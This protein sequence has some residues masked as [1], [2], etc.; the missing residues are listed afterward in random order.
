MIHITPVVRMGTKM[1][2]HITA[3]STEELIRAANKVGVGVR[4]AGEE[5]EHI[6]VS[7]YQSV[8]LA[9]MFQYRQLERDIFA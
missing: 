8:V 7:P 4:N 2:V 3:D 6:T 1:V 5:H 9:S